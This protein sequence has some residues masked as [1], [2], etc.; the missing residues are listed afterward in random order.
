MG[1]YNGYS[2]SGILLRGKRRKKSKKKERRTD[3]CK[4]INESHRLC[5][6]EKKQDMKV[7]TLCDSIYM[8]PKDRKN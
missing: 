7:D 4:N 3:T 8:K 5:R 1:E 2:P 6:E